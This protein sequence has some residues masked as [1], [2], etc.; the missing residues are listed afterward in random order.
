MWSER[1]YLW[2][3]NFIMHLGSQS[4]HVLRSDVLTFFT[5]LLISSCV[6]L[7]N[8]SA[9]AKFEVNFIMCLA[10]QSQHVLQSLAYGRVFHSMASQRKTHFHDG[11][12]NFHHGW[13]LNPLIG[14][15]APLK[16]KKSHVHKYS[17]PLLWYSKLS[18]GASCLH[19]SSLRC[20]YNLIG[21]CLW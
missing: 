9:S 13:V 5:L 18:W 4:Q 6:S 21:V 17:H 8:H 19:W 14:A 7:A 2:V 3:I 11:K 10:S 20:F 16:K 15:V 1:Y 12:K